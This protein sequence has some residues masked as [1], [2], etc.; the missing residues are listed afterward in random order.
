MKSSIWLAMILLTSF[1]TACGGG[2]GSDDPGVADSAET[3]SITSGIAVDPYITGA[4]F[5][6]LS[7]DEQTLIQGSADTSSA[8]G[9]FSFNEPINVGSIIRINLN[10]KGQHAGVPYAGL[11]KRQ[12]LAGD[13][14]P[15]I[16]SPLTTLLAN[17]MSPEAVIEMLNQATLSGLTVSDLKKDPMAV[18]ASKTGTVTESDLVLLQANM[19]VNAFMEATGNFNFGGASPSADSP[20][21]FSD[22]VVLVQESCNSDLYQ[23]LASTIGTDFTV[24][25]M[26]N[27]AVVIT[28]EAIRQI[29]SGSPIDSVTTIDND[30]ANAINIAEGFYQARMGMGGGT[31][32]PGTGGGT[33]PSTPDGQAIFIGATGAT[34]SHCH[35]V[36]TTDTSYRE[37]AG[38]GAKVTTKFNGGAIHNGNT[39]T[40]D[41][42]TALATY[43]DSQGGT[44]T[45]DTGTGGTTDPGTGSGGGTTTPNTP[46]GQALVNS[47]CIGCHNIGQGGTMD[48]SGKGDA[49][50][51]NITSGHNGVSMTDLEASAVADYL[52]TLTPA[53]GGTTD[54]G[55][56]PSTPDGQALVNS[57]CIGCHNI[58]QGGIMDL[59]GKGDAAYTNITSGH[60]GVSMTDLEAN[61]VADYLDTLTPA[62]DPTAPFAHPYFTDA[63]KN[64]RSYVKSN[65]TS[66]C[67]SCH[68]TDL[69]GSSS[70]PSC[71]SCHGQKW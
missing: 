32:D 12:V 57:D 20:V 66:D 6:E 1:L 23:Q 3:T 49:A 55:T 15:V 5:E 63:E 48:L 47:D 43:F 31:T 41:E 61:A 35:T 38:D 17:G 11:I 39:L 25:D 2:G 69:R 45:P 50:Y 65:G 4:Q 59:S 33:T 9:Q 40:T 62:T 58:G 68:G 29:E 70:A 26:A 16:V 51:T 27:M 10:S 36:G 30:L 42:I 44:S 22:I 28:G 71:Y 37:L 8:T 67:V 24:G 54:P 14:D 60:N 21:S 7:A 53:T 18:L 19:A 52:D 56:T 64:H 46:D 13:E 34:C